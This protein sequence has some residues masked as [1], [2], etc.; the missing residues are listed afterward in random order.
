MYLSD[1]H[2]HYA[3]RTQRPV[4]VNKKIGNS[5]SCTLGR[6]YRN[7]NGVNESAVHVDMVKSMIEGEITAGNETIY[8]KGEFFFEK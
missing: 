8:S 1:L 2:L 5:V 4:V 3:I 6:A 7:C